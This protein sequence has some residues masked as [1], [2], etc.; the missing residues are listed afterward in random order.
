MKISVFIY[1]I[2]VVIINLIASF[3]IK[4]SDRA[5]SIMMNGSVL[6]LS[7]LF[8]LRYLNHDIRDFLHYNN[9][10][11]A[12]PV[13]LLLVLLAA[14]IDRKIMLRRSGGFSPLFIT[15]WLLCF[16]T[17]ILSSIL[18]PVRTEYMWWGILSV[19]LFPMLM[20]IWY[21]RGDYPI[22][23]SL[24]AGN[25]V[26]LSYIFFV[27][28]LLL[29]AFTV[30]SLYP[31]GLD[32]G[33]LGIV[34]N[35]NSNGL[36]V[37]P[38]VF[39][40]IY[41]LL[42]ENR[43]RFFNLLSLAFSI[44]MIIISI[45]RTAELAVILGLAAALCLY[46][47]HRDLYRQFRLS[48]ASVIAV[49][50]AIALSVLAGCILMHFDRIDINAYA[51]GEITEEMAAPE[52]TP[53]PAD[54]FSETNAFL[55]KHEKLQRL[56]ALSTGRLSLW[57][58]YG[59]TLK[60]TGHGSPQGELFKGC[61]SSKWAHNNAI[62]IWYASG[63]IAFAGYI[64]WLL[65]GWIFVCRCIISRYRFRNEYMLS[66]MAFLGYFVEAMLEITMYPTNTGIVFL[67]YMMLVPAVFRK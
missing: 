67:M 24:I 9:Y 12:A 35:P 13:I 58:S 20:I 62:D 41:L 19:T 8:M 27:L 53:P 28:S 56:N 43:N 31:A 37:L 2:Y 47:R 33:F 6:L 40:A 63:F 50:A 4:I 14:S 65:A 64:I 11:I 39:S 1:N 17:I 18:Y 48:S 55:A 44:M 7:G 29:S 61:P 42:T 52:E 34:T 59:K 26:L 49:A 46:M 21:K 57:I 5:R 3:S 54:E 22:F 36:I 15:G 25:L 16:I 66:A 51:E 30:N 23:C 45:A 60:F 38:S 32:S 10:K